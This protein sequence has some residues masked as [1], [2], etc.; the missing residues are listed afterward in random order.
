MSEAAGPGG[1]P[2]APADALSGALT[3]ALT[4]ALAAELGRKTGV[5]W[6]RHG[7]ATHPVW[8]V[9]LDGALCLVSGGDEQPL[10]A[11]GEGER[12]EVVMRSKDTGGRLV[13]WVGHA[14]VVRPGDEMWEPVTT[15]LVAGRLNLPD[16]ATAAAGWA[17]SSVVTR[18]LPTGEAVETPGDLSDED[19]RAIPLVT[20]A[21]TRGAL[22]RVLHRRVT[23]RP[24]LD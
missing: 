22:P 17:E 19:H 23:R 24:R 8:H 2:D 1:A 11:L 21:T 12:V 15:A 18:V 3:G 20:P 7:G 14:S 9:W 6:L 10:P 16:L 5:C 4:G 13:T